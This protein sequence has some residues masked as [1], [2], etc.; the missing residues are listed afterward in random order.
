MK[1]SWSRQLKGCNCD[2]AIFAFYE[3][4]EG[5]K[6][7]LP[8]WAFEINENEFSGKAC[9]MA[10]IRKAKI[11]GE[12][13]ERVILLGLGQKKL[14][15]A[16]I[17]AS[18]YALAFSVLKS[19][20]C[21]NI[22]LV[23]EGGSAYAK[24]VS[25]QIEMANYSF[26]KY[27]QK[28][29]EEK[30]AQ[31]PKPNVDGVY[32]ISSA[33][34]SSEISKGEMMGR[35]ANFARSMQNEPANIASPKY[36]ANIAK[37]M[38]QKKGL[39]FKSLGRKELEAHKMNALLSVASGSQNEPALVVLE[40]IG[41]PASK[42]IDVAFVGKGVTFDSGGLS[43]KSN[44]AMEDMKY[45]KSGA[46]AIIGAMSEISN[47]KLRKNIVGVAAFVENMPSGAAYRPGD[48]VIAS[49]GKSIEILNTDAEG[50]V[51]LSDA[52]VFACSQYKPQVL[53]DFATLTGACSVALGDLAAGI[54]SD[55]DSLC[56]TLVSA[57]F[58]SGERVWR[59]PT[60]AEYD[61]KVKS[62]VATLKNVG[63]PGVAGTISGYSFLKAFVQD[64]KWAHIDIAG[65]ANIKK[66]KFGLPVG[67]T[68]FGARLMLEYLG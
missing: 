37:E 19:G 1:F 33:N 21:K 27:I 20:F 56:S 5:A 4:E 59:L 46:C 58:A 9:Q 67:G 51:V 54:L 47:L 36:L 41:N 35:A 61:D 43:L 68:G 17:A 11:D 32:F 7:K 18:H 15:N 53:I 38:A 64:C 63:E 26:D 65:V 45:D 14:L 16:N 10:S 29:K 25:S 50:R 34:I 8:Q 57:G 30:G 52:L 22:A 42:K 66:P 55:D 39:K 48:I 60:W 31:S 13:F 3:P 2:S 12:E 24:V 44:S 23:L 40:Y 6:L 28:Q 62:E 49:N